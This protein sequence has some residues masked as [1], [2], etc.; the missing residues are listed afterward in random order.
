M[1]IQLAVKSRIA[2]LFGLVTCVLSLSVQTTVFAQDGVSTT[3]TRTSTLSITP[4]VETQ[5]IPSTG[6]NSTSTLPTPELGPTGVKKLYDLSIDIMLGGN[7]YFNEMGER[8]Q[9]AGMRLSPDFRY[10]LLPELDFN[11]NPSIQLVSGQT[12]FRFKDANSDNGIFLNE[13][14]LNWHLWDIFILHAGAVNQGYLQSPLLVSDYLAFPGAKEEVVIYCDNLCVKF[15]AEQTIPTSYT[16]ST[17][18]VD[19]EGDP[20]FYAETVS[21]EWKIQKGIKV[22]A[23]GSM[24]TFQNLPSQVA[25]DSSIN[26]NT[27]V[28]LAGPNSSVF[29]YDY[30]GYLAGGYVEARVNSVLNLRLS[31][32]MIENTYAPQNYNQGQLMELTANYRTSSSLMLN[33][34]MLAY[35]NESDTTPA[36]YNSSQLG[37]NNMQ[38]IGGQVQMEFTKAKFKVT[39]RYV[40]GNPINYNLNQAHQQF[41]L[42]QLETKNDIL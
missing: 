21:A 34:S 17:R 3:K 33:P 25:F 8:S 22:G 7:S 5:S 20:S 30:G 4:A 10:H 26:G 19:R 11:L 31:G 6:I 41:M 39:G 24:F 27:V 16:L 29:A 18:T 37:H 9:V 36:Y 35:F 15:V 42:L 38:G 2:F 32:Q 14:T 1:K 12:L 13:A 23:F 40:N 28:A